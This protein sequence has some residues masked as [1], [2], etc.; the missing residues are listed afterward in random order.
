VHERRPG[1]LS[2]APHSIEE[3]LGLPSQGYAATAAN[4]FDHDEFAVTR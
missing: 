1:D 2:P 3:L 4:R